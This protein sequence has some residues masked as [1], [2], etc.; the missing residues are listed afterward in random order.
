MLSE[1]AAKFENQ[2]PKLERFSFDRLFGY[3]T[4]AASLAGLI[5][6]PF[7]ITNQDTLSYVFMAFLSILVL[8]LVAYVIVLERRRLQRYAQ[9]VF[10]IH[11]AQHVTRDSLARIQDTGQDDIQK[12]SEKVLDAVASC[13]SII[14]GKKCRATLIEL[15]HDFK[16]KVVA[17]DSMSEIKAVH[18]TKN[19][20]LS[21]NTDFD[22]LWYSKNGCSRY[23]LNNNIPSSWLA[24]KY[25]SSSFNETSEPVTKK[26]F[27]YSHVRKWPLAYKSALV[28]PIRY[29]S[30][31]SPPKDTEN[32]CPHWHYWGFLCIDSISTRSFDEQYAPDLGACFADMFYAYLS[33]GLEGVTTPRRNPG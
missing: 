28:L 13:F 3:L 19:H 9:A 31:F 1:S 22:N 6:A 7:V 17:R 26:L 25:K 15:E 24:H 8:L 12:I 23:Y 4:G 20:Y 11:F 30:E 10:Y 32:T 18:R 5:A 29:I 21:E 33:Q 14:S 16:L 27:G 2:L